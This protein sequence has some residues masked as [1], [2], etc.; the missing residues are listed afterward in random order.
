MVEQAGM[1]GLGAVRR[2]HHERRRW[3]AR[4][5]E[6]ALGLLL[7]AALLTPLYAPGIVPFVLS[8]APP[9]LACWAGWV[10][11]MPPRG[12]KA[13]RWFAVCDEGVL[14]WSRRDGRP[15]ALAI[16]WDTITWIDEGR[17]DPRSAFAFRLFWLEAD[18][19]R[20][21]LV[22]ERS[23]T[24]GAVSGRSGL[25]RALRERGGWPRPLARRLLVPLAS[26]GSAALLSWALMLLPAVNDAVLG[27]LPRGL[28]DFAR[29]CGDDGEGGGEPFPRAAPYE[30]PG[31]G[32]EPRPW[33]AVEDGWDAHSAT[34]TET[35][36]PEWGDEPDA[37]AVE[38]VACSAA[39]GAVPG[40][41]ISCPYTD[42]PFGLG[43]ATQ[44]VEFARGRYAVTVYE[45]R[46]GELVGEG[47]LEGEE[48]V[49]CFEYVAEGRTE[50]ILT[51][52]E[53][54]AYAA[55]LADVQSAPPPGPSP[56]S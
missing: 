6:H 40:T 36:E 56:G 44:S 19:H 48:E 31:E 7:G 2:V 5:G 30:P 26:L 11:L 34:G 53:W 54:S 32:R 35:R 46:T 3:V 4:G 23:L 18:W 50:R 29:I 42:D 24:V 33:V 8:A 39:T 16:P 22:H 52:P 37:D 51:T 21:D 9:L 13:R 28:E 55:L 25:L 20:A 27:D 47:T 15:A 14:L 43:A 1:A 10:Y 45:A 38:L 12:P 49:E 41:E 17:G